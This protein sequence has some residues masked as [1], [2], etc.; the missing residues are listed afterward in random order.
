MCPEREK[1]PAAQ[2]PGDPENMHTPLAEDGLG[3]SNQH[4][5]MAS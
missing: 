3:V 1:V 2:V 5:T 4:V